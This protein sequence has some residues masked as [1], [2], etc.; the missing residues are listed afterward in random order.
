MSN[1]ITERRGEFLDLAKTFSHI[2]SVEDIAKDYLSI[3]RLKKREEQFLN[4]SRRKSYWVA[5]GVIDMAKRNFM[6]EF[7]EEGKVQRVFQVDFE[8]T[9][10]LQDDPNLR[11]VTKRKAKERALV[12]IR[13]YMTQA[14]RKYFNAGFKSK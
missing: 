6:V 3:R 2:H 14:E 9:F 8:K 12:D 11:N 7:D 10:F 1:Q 13:R 4:G 5:N